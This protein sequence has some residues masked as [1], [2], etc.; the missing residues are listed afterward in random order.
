MNK[1]LFFRLI[2]CLFFSEKLCAQPFEKGAG[3]G[4]EVNALAGKVFKHT[5]KFKAPIPDITTGI[6]AN[7]VWKTQGNE[8]WQQRRNYPTVGIGL[9]FINYGIDSIYGKAIGVY[10]NVELPLIRG[11]KLE[12]TCRMGFG[13]S[14]ATKRYETA[15]SWD[16]INN[17]VGSHVNNFTLFNTT[18][19]YKINKHWD[20]QAGFAFYHISNASLRLP[21]LGINTASAV[22]GFRYFP[23]SNEPKK[24]HR[25]L[26]SL[27]NRLLLQARVGISAIEYG[28]NDGPLYPIYIGSLYASKRYAGKNKI[29]GGVDI[30]YHNHIYSF[31]VNN[32]IN[33]GNEKAN[34]WK[35]SAFLGN[36]FLVGRFGIMM[37]VGYYLKQ[38]MLKL[39]PYYFKLGTN[40]YIIQQEEGLVKELAYAVLL[41]SHQFQAEFVEM[42]LGFG[43]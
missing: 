11:K 8:A 42:G 40:I 4:I 37:Q 41:K 18:I 14:Y 36:E 12:W 21:N 6:E 24:I 5:Q 31:Q 20:V 9:S 22:V 43:F 2:I 10:P 7:L 33:P 13:F 1:R 25:D 19:R 17:A 30:S 38:A 35:S 15:P 28:T 16:T 32:E 27:K 29:F 39:D 3:I 23:V 34:S 26:K